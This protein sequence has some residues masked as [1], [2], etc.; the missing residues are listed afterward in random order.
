MAGHDKITPEGKK[1]FKQ[2]AELKKLQVRIGFTESK[3]GHGKNHESV[4][5]KDYEDGETVAEVAMWNELGT[6]G[7]YPIP[8]RPFMRQSVDK[9]ES[10]SRKM[11]ELQIQAIARG[12]TAEEALKAIGALQVG[13]VQNEIR[14]GGF[15]KNA[16]ITIE[17]GWIW[18]SSGK[19]FYI[20]PK[21]SAKPLIDEGRLRQSVHYVIQAKGG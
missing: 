15:A 17:G 14:N 10:T 7:K 8:S 20:K 9:N 19:P 6:S 12:A 11:C 3:S 5:A 21:K 18:T 13:L 2:I 4:S 16:P 1:F